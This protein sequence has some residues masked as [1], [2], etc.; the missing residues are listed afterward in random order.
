MSQQYLRN[1]STDNGG[2][3]GCSSSDTSTSVC[4]RVSLNPRLRGAAAKPGCG[5]CKKNGE[6]EEFYL[7]HKL[8]DENNNVTCPVLL[9]Y[10]CAVC[11][12]KGRHTVSY[13]PRRRKNG[14]LNT[15]VN[16][17]LDDIKIQDKPQLLNQQPIPVQPSLQ[18]I[19]VN[20]G[21]N[22]QMED[23][24]LKGLANLD[25]MDREIQNRELLKRTILEILREVMMAIQVMN[26][27]IVKHV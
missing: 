26:G 25:L 22:L 5:F 18:P 4:A 23:T 15:S 10:R 11:G 8:R 17:N 2:S 3:A 14:G 24:L 21:A 27:L 12:A 9:E 1:R 6:T 20:Q 16:K 13:C 19:P 7:S